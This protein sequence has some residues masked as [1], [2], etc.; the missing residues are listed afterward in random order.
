VRTF[1]EFMLFVEAD[2]PAPAGGPAVGS[3][4]PGGA[5][6]ATPP[7]GGGMPAISPPAGGPDAGSL[8]GGLGGGPS[9]P[10]DA[11]L[12][13]QSLSGT[14]SSTTKAEELDTNEPW[15]FLQAWY[16]HLGKEEKLLKQAKKL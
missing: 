15:E 16:A 3:P 4:A 14:T 8:L 2:T 10:M 1:K 9:S 13:G 12:G 6:P 11:G 7:S 5:A